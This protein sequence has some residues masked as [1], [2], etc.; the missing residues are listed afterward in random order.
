MD[1]L[2]IFNAQKEFYKSHQTASV[3]FRK[4]SLKKLKKI[5]IANEER[6]CE[7]IYK[8]FRKSAFD[9]YANELSMLYAEIDFF[10]KNLNRLCK[11]QKV[12]INL[13]NMPGSNYIYKEPYGNTLIIGAWNYPYQLTLLPV[14]TA[15]AAGNTCMIKPSELPENTMKLMAELINENFPPEFL[16]VVQGGISETTE[17]LKYPYDKIFFT[18]SP[19]VGK[20]V[21]EA[22]AKNLTPVT[23]E[24]GG[25]SPL[26]ITQ[27]ADIDVAVKRLVWGKFL[28]AG[29]TCI[30]PDYL[31]VEKS[32]QP[33]VLEKL[34]E[35]LE[36]FNYADG[37]EHYTS[38][39]NKRNFDR[40][41]AL[42]DPQKICY[43]G[44]T[45][46]ESLYISPTILENVSW[47]DAVML[48]EIFGPVL[49]VLTYD[50][51]EEALDK[52]NRMEKPL[53]AYLFS[54]DN[55]EKEL[56]L[57]RLSFGGGCINDVIMHVTN[58]RMPFGGVGNSGMGSYHGV[59]GFDTFSHSKSIVKKALWG[60]P[61][62]RYPPY[63]ATKLNLIKKVV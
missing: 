63:T 11:P 37:A 15:I 61:N 50:N 4:E 12:T 36:E 23:L 57:T 34:K 47:T 18:G 38:I 45:N 24:L 16:Y 14:V 49:P 8:D 54:N 46:E 39:I 58:P 19:K 21:Y 44:K 31:L 62:L 40:L 33:K 30:A 56:F 10:V 3:S 6:I 52:I 26:I 51:F 59:Y 7:A 48:E 55:I 60:E 2:S 17:I 25:K 1:Y 35:K 27:S 28:N 5:L 29:Q 9:T 22:A 53:S 42:I 43:G 20:I 13:A 32:I 41:T